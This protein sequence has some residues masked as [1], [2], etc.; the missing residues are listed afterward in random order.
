MASKTRPKKAYKPRDPM[1]VL[2]KTQPW[3]IKAVFDPLLAI[4][5]QLERE[6]TKD[7]ARDGTAIFRD[8]CDGHWYDSHVALIGVCEAY[9]IHEKRAGIVINMEP[10]RRL[11]NKLKYDMPVFASDTQDVRACFARMHQASLSMTVGY[12]RELI[13]DTQIQEQFA[14]LQIE[15]LREAA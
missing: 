6:G 1:A 8:H 14:E 15:Q 10:L 11:A 4:V 5:E 12:A 9:E 3:R 13:R 2:L 7:V